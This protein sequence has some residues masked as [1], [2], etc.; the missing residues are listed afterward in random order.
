MEIAVLRYW[1]KDVTKAWEASKPHMM[2]DYKRKRK[3]ALKQKRKHRRI[4]KWD[5]TSAA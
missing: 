3:E 2:Q 5:Y 4:H 1:R